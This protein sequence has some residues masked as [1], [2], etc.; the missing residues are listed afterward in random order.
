MLNYRIEGNGQPLVL[1]HGFGISFHIWQDLRP[2]LRDHITLIQIEL[3]GIGFSPLPAKGQDYLDSAVEGIEQI[4]I[5][6]G[7]EHWY[8]LSYSSGTRVGERY[9]Q[10]HADC[11]DSSI[12]ICP[13]QTSSLK[14]LGLRL[15]VKLDT[16]IP[17]IGNWILSGSRL[18]FLIDL[19]GFN[20]Q[21]NA[22][23]QLW[24]AEISSQPVEI[25][26]E[27]LRS[28]PD[29]GARPFTIP[30]HRALFIWADEDWLMDTPRLSPC[31][32]LIHAN[33]SA[34]QTAAQPLAD[35]ILPFLIEK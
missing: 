1:I 6:L 7:I 33:H 13:A 32:R 16:Y 2:L 20:L 22:H 28:M 14:A 8:V 29:G 35:L 21:K 3:P 4:R 17:Q 18:R 15:A 12:F 25:L 34:A 9:L 31:V 24:F 26:K 27:T 10:V 5:A 30:D 19:L 23:S 11:V